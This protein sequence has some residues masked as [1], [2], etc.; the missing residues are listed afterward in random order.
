M[1]VIIARQNF[2]DNLM[3]LSFSNILLTTD[4]DF[5]KFAYRYF[6]EIFSF[7]LVRIA[8]TSLVHFS[9]T[10]NINQYKWDHL[11]KLHSNVV[12]ARHGLNS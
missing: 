11:L 10:G 1:N 3:Y 7:K 8:Y 2:L 6:N 12:S 5:S 4:T 9:S